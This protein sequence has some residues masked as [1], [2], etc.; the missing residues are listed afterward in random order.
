MTNEESELVKR[1]FY[2]E[3]KDGD[4]DYEGKTEEFMGVVLTPFVDRNAIREECAKV[5]NSGIKL[6]QRNVLARDQLFYRDENMVASY[7][8]KFGNINPLHVRK[9]LL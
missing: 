3:L 2:E 8:S 5:T 6:F 4:I 1:G 9:K 7:T